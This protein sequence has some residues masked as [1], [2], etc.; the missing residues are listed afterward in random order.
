LARLGIIRIKAGILAC[1]FLS[2]CTGLAA[3]NAQWRFSGDIQRA[4]NL[5][6]ALQTDQAAELL[7]RTRDKS[8]D[9]HKL[10]VQ[11]FCETIDIL[12]TEDEKKFETVERNF[13]SRLRQLDDM[14]ESP[15]VLFLRADLNL[16]RGF[17]YLNLGQEVN[18]VLSIRQAYNLAG[19]CLKKYPHFLPIKK[20]YG[21]LQ[22]MVGSVPDKY[23]WFMSLL[24]MKGSVRIGQKQLEELK[25]SESSLSY[26]GGL[27]YYTIKGFIN[28]QFD[29]A[30]RG[31]IDILKKEPE[32]R[33][34]NFMAINML[35]KNAQSEE[36]S[37][38]IVNL[39]KN[40]VGLPVTYIEYL[41]AE[42]Q[43]QKGDYAGAIHSYQRFIASY[44]SLSFKKD[45]TY[46][47]SLCYYLLGKQPLANEFFQKAR[48]TGRD[49]AEPDR[50]AAY[51]LL[52]T[53]W[54]NPKILKIRFYTDGGYYKEAKALI[55]TVTPADLKLPR[56]K[57]EYFYRKARLA[58][59]TGELS[60]AKIFYQQTID[61]TGNNNWYFA[62]NSALQ[63]GYIAQQQG[64]QVSARKYFEKVLSYRKHEYKGTVD[65]KAKSALESLK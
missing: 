16:Q 51:Q 41:R 21:V 31:L 39:D 3:E 43:L 37:R 15:D 60:A 1:F 28:Q 18:A 17:N 8:N 59:R 56:D 61:M 9:L 62:P 42:I 33:L 2:L 20:T 23:H 58:H 34:L 44:K 6:L 12:I 45:A 13:K 63:L 32:N 40:Q 11:S 5:V 53:Q 4:Y 22:V 65:G 7:A 26:E 24:G 27:L 57:T 29:E 49:V 64:D 54:P 25:N 19:E 50:H 14:P 36:A 35:M 10:Y 47:I 48:E 30:S 38:L 46:K 52:E 55:Q